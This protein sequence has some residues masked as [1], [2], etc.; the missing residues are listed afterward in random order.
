MGRT[1]S[2]KNRKKNGQDR[3]PLEQEEKWA[4][5]EAF[6]TEKKWAGQEAFRTGRKRG[7]TGSL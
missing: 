1:G 2:L 7:R 4:G 5:Q 3:K 6:R